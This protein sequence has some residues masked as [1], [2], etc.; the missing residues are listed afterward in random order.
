MRRTI[1]RGSRRSL[2]WTRCLRFLK[3]SPTSRAADSAAA[4]TPQAL[5]SHADAV[6]R[7]RQANATFVE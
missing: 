3:P 5:N 7:V 2:A 4:A 1:K 6:G